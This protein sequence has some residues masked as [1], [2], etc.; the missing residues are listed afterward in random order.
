[1]KR[2][3]LSL[4]LFTSL[5]AA[6]KKE[7]YGQLKRISFVSNRLDHLKLYYCNKLFY[8]KDD[9]LFIELDNDNLASNLRGIDNEKLND[10]LKNNFLGLIKLSPDEYYLTVNAENAK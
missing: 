10:L 5:Q 7:S 2:L 8:I 9:D 6:E 1:M 4:L 3:L